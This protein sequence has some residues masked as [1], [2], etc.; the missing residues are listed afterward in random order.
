MPDNKTTERVITPTIDKKGNTCYKSI[1]S[2]P[3]NSVAVCYLVPD[4][5]I[6]VIFIPG[7]MGSNLTEKGKLPG[8]A[9]RWRLDS[10][11]TAVEWARP[12]R[13]AE[14]RRKYLTPTVMTL[15]NGGEI[16]EGTQQTNEELRNRGWGEVGKL[17]YGP[18]LVWLE[19]ALN[20]F[21]SARG[22]ERDQLIDQLLNAM[23]GEEALVRDAVALSYR[24]C[25][26]VFASGYNWLDD[27]TASA[28]LL[29]KRIDTIIARYQK[30]NK[31]CEK[32]IIVTHSMGG[33]VARYCSE[34]SKYSDKIFG[35]V[36]GVMPAIGA[37]A[38]YR[39]MKSG[40]EDPTA[41]YNAAGAVASAALGND[42]AEMTA[43]L[44]AAPGPLQLLP[45]PEYG[46]GWLKIKD[47]KTE[48]SLPKSNDPYS[49][50]YT[51]R[52]KWWSLC[53][54]QLI[55]PLNVQ[56]NPLRRQAVTNQDWSAFV[57][58][59]DNKVKIFHDEIKGLYHPNT[60]AF[61]GS[62]Q[63]NKAYGTVT[64][65]G[66]G[67]SWM[68]G[69]HPADVLGATQVEVDRATDKSSGLHE[70]RDVMAPLG[71]KGFTT[72]ERQLYT[73]SKPD[74]HGDGTVPHRSGIA[75]KDKVKSIAQFSTGH[76]PAFKEGIDLV[77]IRRFT[78]RAIVQIAQQVNTTSLKY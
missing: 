75:P 32:V 5:V 4:R 76:E 63:E 14:F 40:T 17:S 54:D 53:E 47:G 10:A 64:W 78:L 6:P 7:V 29:G 50:I 51:V 13:G 43:V 57:D 21:S 34:V 25:F 58:I 56:N 70:T 35:I 31:K 74:E 59:V 42:A 41:W 49:E 19:N 1:T 33:L 77:R 52:G 48:Y 16:S 18:W 36:H 71:G 68:R 22:G 61:F 11:G 72:N 44:S 2:P 45:T 73:I 65:T 38:V 27:N 66:D 37:A 62:S 15:D 39:R 3:D 23:K 55:N 28:I 46:N 60:Y 12:T 67:G 8:N 69:E 20:D 9:I 30:E 26:P 24:Y